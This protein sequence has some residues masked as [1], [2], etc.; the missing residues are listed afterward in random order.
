[1]DLTAAYFAIEQHLMRTAKRRVGI[2]SHWT[3][4]HTTIVLIVIAEW[5]SKK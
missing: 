3:L 2:A 4:C 5:T 1:L